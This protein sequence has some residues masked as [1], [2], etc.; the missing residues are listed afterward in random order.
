MKRRSFVKRSVATGAAAAMPFA[1]RLASAQ[2]PPTGEV[3]NLK[4]APHAGMFK[5]HAG[6]D[7]IDQI[8]FMADTGFRALED[9]GLMARDVAMQKKIGE[10]LQQRGMQMGVFVIDKGGNGANTLAAG[11]QAHLDIF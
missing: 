8:N 5:H 2:V 4:Y 10:T 9:N 6:D 7:L 3:F 1:S 11:K